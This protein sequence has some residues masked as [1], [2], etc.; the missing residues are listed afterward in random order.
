MSRGTTEGQALPIRT[1]GKVMGFVQNQLEI[2]KRRGDLLIF[3]DGIDKLICIRPKAFC[4][5]I[6]N[7]K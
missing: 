7:Y 1:A 2:F 5:S 4:N 6:I 3:F